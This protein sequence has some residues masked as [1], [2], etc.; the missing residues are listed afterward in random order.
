MTRSKP[1]DSSRHQGLCCRRRRTRRVSHDDHAVSTTLHSTA[2]TN[3]VQRI[4]ASKHRSTC[5]EDLNSFPLGEQQETTR[6]PLYYVDQDY[7]ARPEI[8][9]PLPE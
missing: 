2:L 9:Q 1:R 6:T 3:N 8:Q 5:Q 4:T 7:P